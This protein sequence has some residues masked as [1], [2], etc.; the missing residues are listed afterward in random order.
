MAEVKHEQLN[1]KS[2]KSDLP[3]FKGENVTKQVKLPGGFELPW[4]AYQAVKG[5][6][7]AYLW[8]AGL[9]IILGLFGM[10]YKNPYGS[11]HSSSGMYQ[12][13][14]GLNATYN[15]FALAII[16]LSALLGPG[17][18]VLQLKA[19]R[20]ETNVDPMAAFMEGLKYFWRFLGLG[21]VIAVLIIVSLILFIF[22]VFYTFPR[23][24]LAPYFLIDKDL[25]ISES[26][27]ASKQ[28]YEKYRQLWGVIGVWILVLVVVSLIPLIGSILSSIF[29]FFYNPSIAIRYEEFNLLDGGKSPKT[30]VELKAAKAK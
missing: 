20:G 22:P 14:A 21:I 9:P 8:L 30:P 29:E 13:Q 5:N 26:L 15:I 28:A 4:P 19:V 12:A 25:S 16:V 18:V 11:L 27:R 1:E 23:V 3:K 7:A 2:E 17:L 10:L 6:L 24:I